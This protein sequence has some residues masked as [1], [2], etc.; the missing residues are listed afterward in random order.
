MDE[1]FAEEIQDLIKAA[2][3]ERRLT[4]VGNIGPRVYLVGQ[5][6]G[7]MIP[8]I[9]NEDRHTKEV[10][11]MFGRVAVRIADAALDAMTWP[12]GKPGEKR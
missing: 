3:A 5:V 7:A 6:L 2:E 9:R 4:A 8:M 11:E 12:N 10:F 1:K